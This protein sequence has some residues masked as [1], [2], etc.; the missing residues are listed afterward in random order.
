MVQFVENYA[1]FLGLEFKDIKYLKGIFPV[2]LN[3][4]DNAVRLCQAL[5]F[6]SLL[7]Q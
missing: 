1:I 7:A 6:M 4:I 3:L 2:V 5:P